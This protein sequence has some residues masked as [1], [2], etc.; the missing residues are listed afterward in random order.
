MVH[1]FGTVD[2]AEKEV[3]M[4]LGAN[5]PWGIGRVSVGEAG[6]PSPLPGAFNSYHDALRR[7]FALRREAFFAT[8]EV[9]YPASQNEGAAR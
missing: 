9:N 5:G 8:F 4:S 6:N 3:V 2:G 1:A 7:I